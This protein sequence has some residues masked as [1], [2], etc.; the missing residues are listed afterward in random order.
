MQ[1]RELEP[2]EI[3]F[4][5][6]EDSPGWFWL[7]VSPYSNSG[8]IGAAR[9][10]AQAIRDARSMVE[11]LSAQPGRAFTYLDH[12]TSADP[13]QIARRETKEL[14]ETR[15]RRQKGQREE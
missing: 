3:G 4:K 14:K 2:L 9:T 12:M 7:V 6:W 13:S 10:E 5:V 1:R 15:R 8:T 11:D